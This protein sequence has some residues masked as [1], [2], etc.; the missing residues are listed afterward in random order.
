MNNLIISNYYLLSVSYMLGIP[1]IG[2]LHI[3]PHL[4]LITSLYV[5]FIITI[6]PDE[7]TGAQEEK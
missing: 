7:E 3:L 2:L 1:L 4:M 5:V 6:L